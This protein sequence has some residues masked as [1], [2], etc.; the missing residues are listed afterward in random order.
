LTELI[1]MENPEEVARTLFDRAIAL[2]HADSIA[3][4]DDLLARFGTATELSLR[5][6]VAS[7]LTGKG[8]ALR[9]LGRSEDA[10]AVCDD[11]VWSASG[12][13]GS[14]PK[15]STRSR[16]QTWLKDKLRNS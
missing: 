6:L 12:R 5:A 13:A 4:Y 15:C 11:L 1:A 7:A 9:A 2:D 8:T 16:M 3:A 10:I 14:L